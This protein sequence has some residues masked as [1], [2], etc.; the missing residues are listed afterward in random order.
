M[1]G[2]H[3][4]LCFR[5]G[6]TTAR[7]G[8]GS[9]TPLA[10]SASSVRRHAVGPSAPHEHGQHV[11]EDVALLAEEREVHEAQVEIAIA[12]A[13][14]GVV[15]QQP[16]APIFGERGGERMEHAVEVCASCRRIRQIEESLHAI[17][18]RV[19]VEHEAGARHD[20]RPVARLVLL[21]Q[22]EPLMLLRAEPL[23]RQRDFASMAPQ[24]TERPP[25]L[26]R[27][28]RRGARAR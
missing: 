5:I 21:Q 16:R 18:K 27:T 14:Q 9:C 6:F 17:P 4:V 23:K 12:R 10:S 3:S 7:T 28:I 24:Q 25:A 8:Y 1:Y 19:R 20:V 22:E 15:V 13:L 26:L 2:R 11:A